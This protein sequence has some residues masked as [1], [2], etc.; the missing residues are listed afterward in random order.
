MIHTSQL[1]TVPLAQIQYISPSKLSAKK[2]AQ[3]NTAPVSL[4]E[5]F[6]GYVNPFTHE[7]DEPIVLDNTKTP[8]QIING[9]HRIHLA[10]QKGLTEVKAY[11]QRGN[12]T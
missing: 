10:R 1:K 3:L 4:N 11:L 9:R 2:L 7:A 6:S 8:Y 5:T 12:K